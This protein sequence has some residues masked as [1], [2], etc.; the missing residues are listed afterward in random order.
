M[1]ALFLLPGC[2]GGSSPTG[3]SSPSGGS[4]PNGGSSPSGGR[5]SASITGPN[6][7]PITVNTT[8]AAAVINTLLTSVTL[9][10]PGTTT[11]QTIPDI[12]VD[13]GSSGVRIVA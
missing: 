13:T 12:L 11:C 3:G 10:V 7:Q 6:T 9:C 5:P 4:S 2:G 8:F 1:V